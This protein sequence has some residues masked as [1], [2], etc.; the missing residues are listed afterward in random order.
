MLRILADALLLAVR[1]NAPV[2]RAAALPR[3]TARD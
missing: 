2:A 3:L 1:F